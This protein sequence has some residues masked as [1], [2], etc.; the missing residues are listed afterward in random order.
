MAPRCGD[1]AAGIAPGSRGVSVARSQTRAAAPAS[2]SMG[3][4]G[5]R[6]AA[7]IATARKA[8]LADPEGNALDRALVELG[9]AAPAE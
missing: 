8:A 5:A 7:A 9:A 1:S 6:R 2:T 3:A 4:R